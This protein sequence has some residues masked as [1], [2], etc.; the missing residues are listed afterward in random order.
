VVLNAPLVLVLEEALDA[1]EPVEMDLE[2]P[3]DDEPDA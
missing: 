1:A 3:E 2:D